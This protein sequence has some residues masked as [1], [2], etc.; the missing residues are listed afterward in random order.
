MRT[1]VNKIQAVASDNN[2]EICLTLSQISPVISNDDEQT[3]EITCEEVANLVMTN[4]TAHEL[5]DILK[6]LFEE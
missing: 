6:K 3:I 2:S 5:S 4:E 1:F